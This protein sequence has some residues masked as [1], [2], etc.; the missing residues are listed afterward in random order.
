LAYVAYSNTNKTRRL[1]SEVTALQ[2]S[3]RL[4]QLIAN[5]LTLL[6]LKFHGSS[7]LVASS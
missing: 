4:G 5:A 3:L 7:F 6:K 2:Q 1:V